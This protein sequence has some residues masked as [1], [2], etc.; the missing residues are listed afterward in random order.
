MLACGMADMV[1]PAPR[2]SRSA[3]LTPASTVLPATTSGNR[4]TVRLGRL[5]RSIRVGGG[6]PGP[7]P[8]TLL[9]QALSRSTTRAPIT[10]AVVV[11]RPAPILAA[12]ALAALLR[13]RSARLVRG[14][15]LAGAAIRLGAQRRRG[16][17]RWRRGWLGL[18]RLH[19]AALS[20]F[21]AV[22]PGAALTL[23]PRPLLGPRLE[24]ESRGA[25]LS[26]RA[27]RCRRGD[28]SQR[29]WWRRGRRRRG[30]PVPDPF[31]GGADGGSLVERQRL[32]L[33]ERPSP[34][35]GSWRGCAVSGVTAG[36]RAKATVGVGGPRV[37]HCVLRDGHEVSTRW[38]RLPRVSAASR[39]VFAHSRNT[40][41]E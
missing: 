6:S 2:P 17:G 12:P 30:D 8:A 4:L 33:V 5:G 37:V 32:P 40:A 13:P 3:V 18:H 39:F 28:R 16:G 15:G 31:P 10:T 25:R 11:A 23:E 20:R 36:A 1:L 19:H 9:G 21:R 24:A 22:A 14:R 34:P 38:L 41:D 27:R 26:R 29:Q 7:A 35:I